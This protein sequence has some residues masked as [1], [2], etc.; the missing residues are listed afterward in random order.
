MVLRRLEINLYTVRVS[1]SLNAERPC[2][3]HAKSINEQINNCCKQMK[4]KN[5]QKKLAFHF[6]IFFCKFF[7]NSKNLT[8]LNI[9]HFSVSKKKK[10]KKITNKG[11]TEKVLQIQLQIFF[12][13]FLLRKLEILLKS[14]VTLTSI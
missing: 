8:Y 10:S 14:C 6:C 2:K 13:I 9:S 7:R 3:I 11:L 12:C 5:K 1:G 4:L